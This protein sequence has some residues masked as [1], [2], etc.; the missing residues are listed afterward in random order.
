[1]RRTRSVRTGAA[2]V[3]AGALLA[4][5]FGHVGSSPEF[6]AAAGDTVPVPIPAVVPETPRFDPYTVQTGDT[7]AGM[8]ATRIETGV[9]GAG[10]VSVLFEG[11]REVTG[12]F[13]VM[14]RETEPYNAGDVLFTPDRVWQRML[15]VA[16]ALDR[17][18]RTFA[19]QFADEAD[20]ERF[21]AAGSTGRGTLLIAS[22]TAA[23][24]EVLEG[25]ADR[26]VVAEV[27]GLHVIPPLPPELDNPDFDR[28][29]RPFPR[30]EMAAANTD[31]S[32]LDVY[33]WLRAVSHTFMAGMIYNGKPV[34]DAQRDQVGEWLREAYTDA[35]A[36][37]MLDEHV[38]ETA[39]GFLIMGGM[40]GLLP[41]AKIEDVRDAS[42][43]PAP[44][45]RY[46]FTA[47]FVLTGT[48]DAVLTCV[49]ESTADGWKI[50]ESRLTFI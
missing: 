24:A 1:M 29:M 4:G 17:P 30:L 7:V 33:E 28:E 32:A 47:T 40:S 21:G 35:A 27:S 48:H 45:G 5:W 26:A 9:L 15:P 18:A 41:P 44:G 43:E 19:L 6:L 31:E 22:Y 37:R 10:S 23:Y 39:D 12:D 50:D 36:E 20:R 8:T 42:V 16:E 14:S 11:E 38:P 13:Q 2:C 25:A 49:L 34:S 3:L 46:T